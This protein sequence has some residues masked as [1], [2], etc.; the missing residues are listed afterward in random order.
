M[1][2]L[3][4]GVIIMRD[5]VALEGIDNSWQSGK[6]WPINALEL[7]LDEDDDARTFR[8]CDFYRDITLVDKAFTSVGYNLQFRNVTYDKQIKKNEMQVAL[9]GLDPMVITDVLESEDL[10]NC[11]VNFIRTFADLDAQDAPYMPDGRGHFITWA[12]KVFSYLINVGS[13][14]NGVEDEIIAA[15]VTLNCRNTLA[16]LSE[17]RVGRFTSLPSFQHYFP[18][19]LSMEFVEI[20]ASWTPDFGKDLD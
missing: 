15:T 6:V 20:I 1:N 10:T 12:G 19:D 9:G 4:L 2:G 11:H 8:I 7:I 18:G 3:I 5:R 17:R 14:S 13:M 16:L